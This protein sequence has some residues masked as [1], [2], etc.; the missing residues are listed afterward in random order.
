[1]VDGPVA[2]RPGQKSRLTSLT[3]PLYLVSRIVTAFLYDF[4]FEIHNWKMLS[5]H[6]V[7]A[8]IR[9]N[10]HVAMSGHPFD[11]LAHRSSDGNT[12]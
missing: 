11:E 6:I 7:I 2:C 9:A 10:E 3:E 4:L 8:A 1:M 5:V 12:I